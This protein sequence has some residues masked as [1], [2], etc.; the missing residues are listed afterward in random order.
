MARDLAHT[1]T[2]KDY[3]QRTHRKLAPYVA[4]LSLLILER[5]QVIVVFA[6]LNATEV[7]EDPALVL[8]CLPHLHNQSSSP[9]G[10]Q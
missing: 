6:L 1:S 10:Q 7:I 4:A 2:A 8:I 3:Q 5:L 9:S